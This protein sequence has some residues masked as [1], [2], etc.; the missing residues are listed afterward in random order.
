VKIIVTAG[1]LFS[2]YVCNAMVDITPPSSLLVFPI[3]ILNYIAQ[4]LTFDDRES[5]EESMR[6]TATMKLTVL[7]SKSF[8]ERERDRIKC[9]TVDRAKI[10]VWGKHWYVD[11]DKIFVYDVREGNIAFA[12][13][14]KNEQLGK[15]MKCLQNIWPSRYMAF[16]RDGK[17]LALDGWHRPCH[18]GPEDDYGAEP[19]VAI[20]NTATHK[21]T[22]YPIVADSFSALGFNK[23][24]TKLLLHSIHESKGYQVISLTS[25]AEHA[26]KSVKAFDHFLYHK[27]ICKGVASLTNT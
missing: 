17:L 25:D 23:Q 27:R 24:N 5:D 7:H 20:I 15:A 22:K 18:Y 4:F 26:E 14:R 13:K 19:I 2:T 11:I 12:T 9:Y 3:E 1:F 16:S 10:L 21:I 8:P 6:R